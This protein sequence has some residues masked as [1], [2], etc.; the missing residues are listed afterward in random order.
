MPTSHPVVPSELLEKFVDELGPVVLEAHPF[1]KDRWRRDALRACLLASR[2]LRHFALPYLYNHIV[3][4]DQHVND[5]T[6]TPTY[7]RQ[8]RDVLAP[9]AELPLAALTRVAPCV[10][11]LVIK[12]VKR[13][14]DDPYAPEGVTSL[15]KDEGLP[16]I[17]H[18]LHHGGA[19]LKQLDIIFETHRTPS[20]SNLPANFRAALA[21]LIRSPSLQY[22]NIT[23]L[24]LPPTVL[25]GAHFRNLSLKSYF[26]DRHPSI[27]HRKQISIPSIRRL[28]F[29][30]RLPTLPSFSASLLRN[31]RKLVLVNNAVADTIRNWQILSAVRHTLEDLRLEYSDHS[32]TSNSIFGGPFDFGSIPNLRSLTIALARSKGHAYNN[33]TNDSKFDA[34]ASLLDMS[35]PA[36]ALAE[37]SLHITML[38]ANV[39]QNFFIP[40]ELG[41]YQHWVLMDEV[42]SGEHYPSLRKVNIAF[43]VDIVQLD[44]LPHVVKDFSTTEFRIDAQC[45]FRAT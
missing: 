16:L 14:Y 44:R 5:P 42:L 38:E 39:K 40:T 19:A 1:P 12:V 25:L 6:P 21:A 30:Q 4:T 9:D 18:A 22:L 17:L 36:V 10:N 11:V 45:M 43:E 32:E 37:I 23:K 26:C 3:I 31:L 13:N 27:E 20:W 28:A 29:E 33:K 35:T 8:L 7:L 2:A 24:S 41:G 34:L 15:T